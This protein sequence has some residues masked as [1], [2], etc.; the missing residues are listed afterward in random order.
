MTA[1]ITCR[2]TTSAMLEGTWGM[3]NTT[4]GGSSGPAYFVSPST[5]YVITTPVTW[6]DDSGGDLLGLAG[7]SSAA[8][9]TGNGLTVNQFTVQRLGP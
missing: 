1:T 9:G 3:E 6:S 8:N 4:A 2:S 5:G 7:Q